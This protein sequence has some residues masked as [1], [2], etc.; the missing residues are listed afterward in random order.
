MSEPSK[1]NLDLEK[2]V[3]ALYSESIP[4]M[5]DENEILTS[6]DRLR[7]SRLYVPGNQPKKILKAGTDFPDC[8]ILDLED[9]VP[10]HEKDKARIIVRN[11]LRM[12]DFQGAERNVRINS[13]E[14]G[15]T[16]L[17]FIIAQNVHAILIPKVE[18]CDQIVRINNT[19]NE[20]LKVCGRE[21]PVFIIPIIESAHGVL[22][23]LEIAESSSN[24]IGLTIGL[25]DY[26]ADLG[27]NKTITGEE[28]FFARSMV[29]HAAKAAGIQ[30]LDSVHGDFRDEKSLRRSVRESKALGF[31]GV[32]C[33][34][35]N[36]IIPIHE[37]FSP[38][39]IEISKAKE[40]IKGFDLAIANGT[41]VFELDGK[42]IDAPV[43][44]R[45]KQ[46]IQLAIACGSLS[47]D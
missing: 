17:E 40:I 10:P 26:T 9:S 14:D 28:S 21:E 7:R 8:I 23:A 20:I 25:E 33:I 2:T 31:V 27:I 11:A 5:R 12:A 46:T 4:P 6:G 19:I 38:L 41:S 47:K 35:P 45:A 29:L 44:K 42:M 1:K 36:Q 39:E 24:I 3:Q 37:E 15:F 43:V 30:A 32:G 18:S 22:N 16:D 34:H 13:G